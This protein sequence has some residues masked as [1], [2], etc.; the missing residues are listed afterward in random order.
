MPKQEV[1]LNNQMMIK[2]IKDLV[3]EVND[4]YPLNIKVDAYQTQNYHDLT[5]KIRRGKGAEKECH[6]HFETGQILTVSI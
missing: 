6:S 5:I 1:E 3:N 2:I 4:S